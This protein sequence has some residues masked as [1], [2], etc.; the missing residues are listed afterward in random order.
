MQFLKAL[1]SSFVASFSHAMYL[2]HR[3]SLALDSKYMQNQPFLITSTP[4][5]VVSVVLFPQPLLGLFNSAARAI[6]LKYVTPN[7]PLAQNDAIVTYVTGRKAK[8]LQWP[9]ITI[10]VTCRPS[11]KL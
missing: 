10:W 6:L 2:I 8:F 5:I 11:L 4:N 7:Q 3:K 1:R 9:N